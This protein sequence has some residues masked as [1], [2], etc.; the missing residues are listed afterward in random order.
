MTVKKGDTIGLFL[1]AVRDQLA[2]EFRELRHVGMD[3]LM[4]IKVRE[5]V[6]RGYE[7]HVWIQCAG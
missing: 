4:Y 7:K 5:S 6:L 3:N 1:K 2:S